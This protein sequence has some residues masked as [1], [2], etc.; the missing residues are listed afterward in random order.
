MA[1]R[2]WGERS[3]YV[4][5]Q[6]A[7]DHV[8]ANMP[9]RE[10]YRAWQC[11]SFTAGTGQIRECDLFVVTPVGV[12]LVEIK[13]HPGRA[14]NRGGTWFFQG[15]RRHVIDNPL[16]LTN[17]KAKELKSRLAWAAQRLKIHDYESPFFEAAVFLSAPDLRCEFDENQAQHVYGR[18]GLE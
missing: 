7:L 17:Q 16:Y 4:W 5:E 18:D 15:E 3:E 8:R 11:F 6:E 9:D 1:E 14:T 12:F 13:S 2:R 10:P